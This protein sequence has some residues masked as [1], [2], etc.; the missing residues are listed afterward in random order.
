MVACPCT[1]S[2]AETV[3]LAARGWARSEYRMSFVSRSIYQNSTT[4]KYGYY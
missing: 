4:R 3:P 1:K 2:R